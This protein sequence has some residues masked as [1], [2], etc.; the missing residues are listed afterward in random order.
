[1][2]LK[3][4]NQY[5]LEKATGFRCGVTLPF[6]EVETTFSDMEG[7]FNV[8]LP[9]DSVQPWQSASGSIN[10]DKNHAILG[11]IAEAMERYSAAVIN[12]PIK[13]YSQLNNKKVILPNEFSLFSE[14]QY[15]NP[16]FL[17]K[18]F[19]LDEAFFGEVYSVYT[20]ES[21]WV[22]Q[23]LIGLGTKSEKALIPST[24]TGL[25]AHFDKFSAMLLAVQELLERDALTVYWLNSL[26]G[27][28][29]QLEEKYTAPVKEKGGEIF[30]FDITQDWNPH[31]VIIVCG[32]LLQ[33]NKKR[34]S[35]GVAC[36][37]NYEKAIEK[38]YVEW[39]QGTTFAGFYDVYHPGLVLNHP[40]DLKDFDEHAVYYTLYPD[41][42]RDVPLIKKRK[43]HSINPKINISSNSNADILKQLLN[44][45]EKEKIR[46]FYRD[47]TLPDVR[48]AG[49][50]VVR[51]LSPELSL[52]H[53]DER[54][55]FLGGRTNDVVWR[56]KNVDMRQVEFPNK[57]P[58]PL[59]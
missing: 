7:V 25:A 14:D 28:E 26:G 38:A 33:R 40:D 31:P 18:K 51:V 3:T 29:I 49:L 35:M 22:P 10:R 43:N 4:L 53:G 42:W 17:W 55:P 58:H 5:I 52:I 44:E 37:E 30:C 24:S 56:N 41:K 54:A 57:F 1:M 11:A 27:R 21:Y 36:R 59:G 20:N 47:L 19:G 50:T 13:K 16:D 2:M 15:N 8:S 23:E 6:Q 34:I 48:E 32:Y 39:I 9:E 12:F 46:I 45:L